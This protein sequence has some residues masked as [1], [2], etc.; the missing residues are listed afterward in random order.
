MFSYRS[1]Y[2][3]DQIGSTRL[4]TDDMGNM[5]YAAAHDPYG[6]VQQT[7]V[8][9]FNPE[10]KFSGKEQDAESGLYYFGARYYDPTLYRF[11]SPDPMFDA[12]LMKSD[13]QQWNLYSYCKNNPM[14]F[15]DFGGMYILSVNTNI[16][17][18]SCND[19][20]PDSRDDHV[21][22]MRNPGLTL[23][24]TGDVIPVKDEKGNV[25]LHIVL[26]CNIYIWPDNQLK[27]VGRDYYSILQHELSHRDQVMKILEKALK[28]IE[29]EYLKTYLLDPEG[30]LNNA[31]KAV[32]KAK[33]KAELWSKITKDYEVLL[34]FEYLFSYYDD[35]NR[36]W[37]AWRDD[38][39][40]AWLLRVPS[41]CN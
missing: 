19:R 7:W 20:V 29:E 35:I 37:I 39:Y 17:R 31:K 24:P 16:I 22:Y 2:P 9:V 13:T 8:N 10:L 32:A 12:S 41:Y 33:R 27:F 14:S 1:S 23:F 5:V 26:N 40:M 21:I 38:P 18:L 28:K 15:I 6:G 34:I 30:A 11:L 25:Q 3:T 4:V 36:D